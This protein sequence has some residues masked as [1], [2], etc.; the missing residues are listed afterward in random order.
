M[1]TACD[2]YSR[3]NIRAKK[4][5]LVEKKFYLHAPHIETVK[6]KLLAKIMDKDNLKIEDFDIKA[7]PLANTW[8]ISFT[9]YYRYLRRR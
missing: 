5:K 2:I 8:E 9:G 1:Q 6:H 7:Y 3:E 4:I